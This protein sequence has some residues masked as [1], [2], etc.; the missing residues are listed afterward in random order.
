MYK[1]HKKF[2][3]DRFLGPH[4]WSVP[5]SEERQASSQQRSGTENNTARATAH[6]GVGKTTK[7]GGEFGDPEKYMCHVNSVCAEIWSGN[8]TKG[9]N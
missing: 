2:M 7:R 8:S 5:A 6:R 9:R 4:K 1:R 3:A